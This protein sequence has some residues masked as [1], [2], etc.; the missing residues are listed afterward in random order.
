MC[1]ASAPSSL[2]SFHLCLCVCFTFVH[3]RGHKNQVQPYSFYLYPSSPYTASYNLYSVM[4]YRPPYSYVWH[5]IACM[6]YILC[7]LRFFLAF[8]LCLLLSTLFA[9]LFWFLLWTVFNLLH[10]WCCWCV[11]HTQPIRHKTETKTAQAN[12]LHSN[13]EEHLTWNLYEIMIGRLWA[14]FAHFIILVAAETYS[15]QND[16]TLQRFMMTGHYVRWKNHCLFKRF[17]SIAISNSNMNTRFTS[18]CYIFAWSVAGY[19][20]FTFVTKFI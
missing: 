1:T 16:R 19:A 2:R 12:S 3:I 14:I 15:G 5:F 18:P 20:S 10:C 17:N 13:S 7:V 4:L 8:C 9:K 6:I 11:F